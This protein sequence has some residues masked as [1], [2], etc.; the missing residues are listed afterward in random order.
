[1]KVILLKE[2]DLGL[3]RPRPVGAEMDIDPATATEWIQAG[4]ARLSE[5]TLIEQAVATKTIISKPAEPKT[6]ATTAD[7]EGKAKS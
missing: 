5:K 4:E 1:M 3:T 7:A 2:K 6:A